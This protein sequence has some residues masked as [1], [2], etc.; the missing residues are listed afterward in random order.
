MPN[1]K[2]DETAI[3]FACLALLSEWQKQEKDHNYKMWRLRRLFQFLGQMLEAERVRVQ[4]IIEPKTAEV[5]PDPRQ[6]SLLPESQAE[7]DDA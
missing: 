5:L 6:L 2:L 3:N 7:V 1:G 4:L